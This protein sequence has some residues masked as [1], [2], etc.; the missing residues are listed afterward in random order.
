MKC[1]GL[2]NGVKNLTFLIE[3][4]AEDRT[5]DWK[6]AYQEVYVIFKNTEKQMKRSVEEQEDEELEGIGEGILEES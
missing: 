3:I 1:L 2:S 5:V 4:S 6:Q